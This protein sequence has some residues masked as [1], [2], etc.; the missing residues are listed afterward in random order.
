MSCANVV[1]TVET[2][3]TGLESFEKTFA[4]LQ[5]IV[6]TLESGSVSL[7]QGMALFKEGVRCSTTCKDML[8]HARHELYK[9]Q[10]G[11]EEPCS[12]DESAKELAK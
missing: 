6:R 3:T 12:L 9:W 4:R 8:E 5:E 11:K 7:D 10:N 1:S 2:S